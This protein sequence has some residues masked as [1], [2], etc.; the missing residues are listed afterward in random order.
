MRKDS[1]IKFI[2]EDKDTLELF[3]PVPATKQIPD[4]YKS[5]PNELDI[6]SQYVEKEGTPS[7]KRCVP[8]LDYLTSGYI[9]RNSYEVDI[10]PVYEDGIKGFEM[11][12]NRDDYV[13][14]HPWVQAPIEINGKRNHYFK[15]Q[16][17]WVIKTP[18]G[19]SCLIYQPHYM[20]NENFTFLPAI[21]DTDTHDD[22]IGMI[23][24]IN[25]EEPFTIQPGD[26]LVTVFPFK[27]ESWKMETKY[28]EN[29]GKHSSFKYFINGPW[30]G[31][32]SKFLHRKKGYR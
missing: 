31:T 24:I 13:A 7:I 25:T 2:T 3:P 10:K 26:P 21:V 9:L 4:W 27:R 16:Q 28:D 18:P 22:F 23:G 30:H 17:R 11:H 15:I 20:F 8:V 29:V 12:C 19:Y 32:Y 1:I 5:V 14:A 6:I